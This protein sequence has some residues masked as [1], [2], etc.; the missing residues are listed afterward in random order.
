M[1][2]RLEIVDH[3]RAHRLAADQDGVAFLEV[4][5]PRGQRPVLHLDAEEL[6]VFL[7]I[8]AGDAVGA[9]QR[10]A[11][12]FQAD[13]DEMAIVKAQRRIAGGGEGEKGVVPVAHAE[14]ALGIES[15]HVVV[16]YGA[17]QRTKEETG[18][19]LAARNAWANLG[20]ILI[21]TQVAENCSY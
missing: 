15:C 5:Q 20:L 11:F 12:D 14:D 16:N 10:L 2:A 3:Q 1:L 13:H 21:L 7:V 6:E 19:G 18:R 9:H 17:F 8:G 4:L